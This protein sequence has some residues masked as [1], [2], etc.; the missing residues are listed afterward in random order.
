MNI[1]VNGKPHSITSTNLA[2]LLVELDYSGKIATALNE[3]FIPSGDRPS[4]FLKDGDRIEIV[5]PMEGG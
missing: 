2:D 1:T 5:A 4:I 3:S